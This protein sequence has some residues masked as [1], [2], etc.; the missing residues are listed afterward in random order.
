M[1]YGSHYLQDFNSEELFEALNKAKNDSGSLPTPL[2]L[3]KDYKAFS[4][5]P[6]LYGMST[7]LT[8]LTSLLERPENPLDS[9]IA[10]T[11]Q[12]KVRTHLYIIFSR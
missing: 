1:N 4:I 8:S 11:E 12:Q 9:M 3:V 2:L 6:L 7:I 10:F 5:P